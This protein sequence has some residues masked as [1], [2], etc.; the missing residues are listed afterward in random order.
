MF[1][2]VVRLLFITR[3]WNW[4]LCERICDTNKLHGANFR[5]IRCSIWAVQLNEFEFKHLTIQRHLICFLLFFSF[6]FFF[7]FCNF[8][9]YRVFVKIYASTRLWKW[10]RSEK[11]TK[12]WNFPLNTYHFRQCNINYKLKQIEKV[13]L[14]RIFP[15]LQK[16]KSM[17]KFESI[18]KHIFL[19]ND[20]KSQRNEIPYMTKAYQHRI[21]M[22]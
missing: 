14:F 18:S 11:G 19:K 5:P 1:R 6:N 7:N 4:L 2:I 21:S 20:R 15:L 16:S 17:R 13:R 3:L 10:T 9:Q 8:L 12:Q 22:C